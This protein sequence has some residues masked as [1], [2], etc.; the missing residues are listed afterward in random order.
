MT[1]TERLAAVMREARGQHLRTG[2]GDC[3]LCSLPGFD[4]E[5]W[6][7]YALRRLEAAAAGRRMPPIPRREKYP[8]SQRD[9]AILGGDPS[10]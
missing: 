7:C 5:P 8:F 2:S 10:L 1:P 9:V 3:L 4:S 6:P